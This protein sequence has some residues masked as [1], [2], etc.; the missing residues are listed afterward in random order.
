MSAVRHPPCPYLAGKIE[1]KSKKKR[2]PIW[3]YFI[4]SVFVTLVGRMLHTPNL[5]ESEHT[6]IYR[7]VVADVWSRIASSHRARTV[8]NHIQYNIL[9][10]SLNKVLMSP[11]E[12]SWA[13]VDHVIRNRAPTYRSEIIA[14]IAHASY[15]EISYTRD[16][17]KSCWR[18]V[19]NS[20]KHIEPNRQNFLSKYMYW[21]ISCFESAG[22]L[23]LL[24]D[25]INNNFI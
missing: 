4:H 3:L 22:L 25:L 24:S 23:F 1:S 5:G 21:Y 14:A 16:L 11:I 12:N 13:M 7:I 19:P 20:L 9:M 15:Y 6:E 8:G 2:K 17:P 18:S 10:I